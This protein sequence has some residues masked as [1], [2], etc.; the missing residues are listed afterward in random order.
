[1]YEYALACYMSDK[2]IDE[3]MVEWQKARDLEAEGDKLWEVMCMEY[4]WMHKA[5][6]DHL[7]AKL[8]CTRVAYLLV[9]ARVDE[10]MAKLDT[11]NDVWSGLMYA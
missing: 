4:M 10:G 11:F 9:Q 6:P 8:D 3:L 7:V 1:M 5:V 2:A